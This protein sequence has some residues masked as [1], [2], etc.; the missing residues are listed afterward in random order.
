MTTGHKH[1][2]LVVASFETR[3]VRLLRKPLRHETNIVKVDVSPYPYGPCPGEKGCPHRLL[4]PRPDCWT[5]SLLGILH[6][7]TGLTLKV[8][9]EG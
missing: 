7:W 3:L 8:E 9:G 1:R 6:R 5:L 4:H 2:H